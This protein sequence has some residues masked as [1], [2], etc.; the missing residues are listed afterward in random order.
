MTLPLIRRGK[1]GSPPKVL[2]FALGIVC[3][4]VFIMSAAGNEK[5]L[6]V[7]T[8]QNG[9]SVSLQQGDLLDGVR[10]VSFVKHPAGVSLKKWCGVDCHGHDSEK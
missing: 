1:L 6:R 4:L 2:G 9:I 7:T 8:K 5:T 10:C 3:L